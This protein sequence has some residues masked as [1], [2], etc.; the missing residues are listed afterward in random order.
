[1]IK[2]CEYNDI[3]YQLD[4][5]DGGGTDSGVINRSN[6]G[7]RAVK[8]SVA[9]RYVHGPNTVV[10]IK[11]VEASIELLTNYVNSEFMFQ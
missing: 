10:N 3:K 6:Y 1:M 7:V 9:T 8:I 4:A 11:E 2:C 5:I